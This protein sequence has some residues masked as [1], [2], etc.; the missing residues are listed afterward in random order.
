M[1][2]PSKPIIQETLRYLG[3]TVQEEGFQMSGN[4]ESKILKTNTF[5]TIKR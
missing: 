2:N 4:L 5:D 3:H 1:S